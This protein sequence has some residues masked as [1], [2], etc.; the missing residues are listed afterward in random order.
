M[1][2]GGRAE[3]AAGKAALCEKGGAFGGD[4]A[5]SVSI[6]GRDLWDEAKREREREDELARE[7]A[8][9]VF[10][11]D[12]TCWHLQSPISMHT[13]T[14]SQTYTQV[15]TCAH[16][17]TFSLLS[18][19]LPMLKGGLRLPPPGLAMHCMCALPRRAG[20]TELTYIIG[21]V[22]WINVV[23]YRTDMRTWFCS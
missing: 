1:L 8:I 11:C 3:K 18:P 22:L 19:N 6:V 14:S 16:A 5:Q 10:L 4:V 23:D 21:E 12:V 17:L 2:S 20:A 13:H 9:G 15:R 7:E